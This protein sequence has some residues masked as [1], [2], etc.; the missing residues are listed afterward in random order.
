MSHASRNSA[1]R[2]RQ[3][4]SA[5]LLVV[6]ASCCA[7]GCAW[8]K[9]Q[10]AGEGF[11]GWSNDVG[12][13]ARVAKKDGEQAATHSGYFLDRKAQEIE[14]HLGGGFNSPESF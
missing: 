14:E 1:R 6:A 8:M 7:P 10:V 2:A 11:Q 12:K 4:L 9:K 13:G 3:P 5:L